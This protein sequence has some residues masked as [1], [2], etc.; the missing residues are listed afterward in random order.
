MVGMVDQVYR[1]RKPQSSPLWRCLANSFNTFTEVYEQRY[2]SRYGYLRPV[3]EDVVDKFMDCGNLAQGFARV[4]CD[5]CKHE[6]LLAFSCKG[7][8]FCPSC[9]QKKVQLFGELLTET[10]LYPVPHRHYT[11]SIPR[12]LRIYFRYDRELLKDLCR[13]ARD[14]LT[15]YMRRELG[16]SVGIPGVVMTIHTYGDALNWHPHLHALVADGLFERSRW[17][18]VMGRTSLKPL[19]ELFRA[20]VLVFLVQ[21]GVLPAERARMLRSWKHSGFNVYH[22]RRISPTKGEDL[23][24]LARYIIRNPFSLEKMNYSAGR[25]PGEEG[26]VIYR[27]GKVPEGKSQRARGK[28]TSKELFRSKTFEIFSECDFIA[29]VTQHI[30][31]KSFQLVRYYGWYS[32]KMRGQRRKQEVE[33]AGEPDNAVR[34]I[35]V[36]EYQP[37]RIP[38]AKW[39]ELIKKVWEADPLMCPRCGHEMRIVALIDD[40]EIIEKILRHV[41]FWEEGGVRARS[42]SPGQARAGPDPPCDRIL[43]PSPVGYGGQAEPCLEDPFPD[44]DTEPVMEHECA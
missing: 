12:M 44:Y 3:I 14:C 39:R 33:V 37:R 8:W 19:E 43:P 17:F 26:S 27:V 34:V 22:S 9:H 41:G 16:R 13:I 21:R 7:R 32:N 28:R 5:H 35:D 24:R 1:P 2:Q 42:T 4:R 11:F 10:I 25:I 20:R 6:Y 29:A 18:Y 15:E 40:G 38:S 36:S 31:D 30:P 23:E